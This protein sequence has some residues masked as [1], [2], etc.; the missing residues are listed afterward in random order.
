M[1][2][3][4]GEENKNNNLCRRLPI[5]SDDSTGFSFFLFL[6]NAAN[7]RRICCWRLESPESFAPPRAD[8]VVGH[9]RGKL[10]QVFGLGR[11]ERLE[12]VVGVN[13]QIK[14]AAVALLTFG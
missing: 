10:N 13:K 9:L 14:P 2:R 12:G 3:R 4:T 8:V 7:K 11:C 5:S 1:E 6:S